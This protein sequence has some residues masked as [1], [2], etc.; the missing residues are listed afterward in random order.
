MSI[1]LA[2]GDLDDRGISRVF[3][4][5]GKGGGARASAMDFRAAGSVETRASNLSVRFMRRCS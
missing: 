2:L 4:G 5:G 1:S 3:R